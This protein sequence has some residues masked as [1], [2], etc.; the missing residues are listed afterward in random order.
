MEV[1]FGFAVKYSASGETEFVDCAFVFDVVRASACGHWFY[2]F[3][4]EMFSQV[5]TLYESGL[6]RDEIINKVECQ[7]LLHW[8][9]V[10]GM[11]EKTHMVADS[12]RMYDELEKI[13][14]NEKR[15]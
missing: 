6:A 3:L 9:P 11:D 15:H 12:G 14:R 1:V 13:A 7:G 8:L 10:H 2:V 4:A 5:K